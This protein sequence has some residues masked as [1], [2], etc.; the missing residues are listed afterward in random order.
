MTTCRLCNAA[1]SQTWTVKDAKSSER[2]EMAL[3]GGCGLVQQV[4][5]PSDAEL[6]IYY[7]HNYREDYKSTH[8]PKL[9]YVHRAGHVAKDRLGFIARAGI[10][11]TGKR[12]LDVGAGGGE[13]CYIASKAGFS[14]SGIEP[15]HGYSEFARENYDVAIETAGI[16]DLKAKQA[17]VVTLFH[18]FEHLAHPQEVITKIWSVLPDDGHLIIEVPN[19]HQSDASPHNIYF[20]AHLFYYSRFSL[21]AAA[22]QYFEPIRLE[23][24]GNLMVAFKKRSQP[25]NQQVLPA[26]A[27]LAVTR[28]RLSQKGW[29]E[30]LF[31]GGGLAKPFKRVAKVIEEAQLKKQSPRAT[32][33]TAWAAS[34]NRIPLYTA[35]GAATAIALLVEACA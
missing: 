5:L 11:A 26:E 14:V 15:H 3:C 17:D 21:M 28:K 9:K 10:T 30:Y 18:V 31:S 2:L 23:D 25:L 24:S 33:D 1:F 12:L 22:G 13:F 35:L 4:S 32:L 6:K 7:S 16:A 20:K 27:E 34:K 8:K 29:M 19:I